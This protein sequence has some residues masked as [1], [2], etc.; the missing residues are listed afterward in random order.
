MV[1]LVGELE[2]T[3]PV[4]YGTRR[5]NIHHHDS[6]IIASGHTC[7]GTLPLSW[8]I[9]ELTEPARLMAATEVPVLVLYRIL[10]CTRR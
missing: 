10:Y 3:S 2:I 4:P 5:T 7:H 9:T 1:A 8:S 6:S